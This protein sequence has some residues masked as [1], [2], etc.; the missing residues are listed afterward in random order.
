MG[1]DRFYKIEIVTRTGRKIMITHVSDPYGVKGYKHIA[2]VMG[3]KTVLL[4][5]MLQKQF[6]GE[7][8]TLI[9]PKRVV[10]IF[11]TEKEA[12]KVVEYLRSLL[13]AKTMG[14]Y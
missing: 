9:M 10:Y 3:M 7:R 14:G 12:C 6:N 8:Y 5:N 2:K 11:S 1:A 13:M 4:G